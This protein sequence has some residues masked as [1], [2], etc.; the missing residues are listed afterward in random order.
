LRPGNH[1]PQPA[2]LSFPQRLGAPDLDSETWDTTG[3]IVR[4][5]PVRDLALVIL[6]SAWML[7]A[8]GLDSETWD[9]TGSIVRNHPVR[10]LALVILSSTWMLGAPGLDSETWDTMTLYRSRSEGATATKSEEN[11]HFNA[12]NEPTRFPA[13][14]LSQSECSMGGPLL[15]GGWAASLLLPNESANRLFPACHHATRPASR[16]LPD[17]RALI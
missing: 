14:K 16:P 8:P 3:S 2:H 4:N 9:T 13:G 12:P 11:L 17:A 7:G 1:K 6:S 5:H 15:V 10:D